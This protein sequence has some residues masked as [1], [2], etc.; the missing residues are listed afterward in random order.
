[1]QVRFDAPLWLH[2]A[3]G[4]WHFVTVPFAVADEIEAVVGRSTRGFGSVRVRVTIGS[5]TWDT[6]VF[7]DS[8]AQS[9]V[10]PI[11]KAVRTA[12]GLEVGT[13]TFV[14]MTVLDVSGDG[15]TE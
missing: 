9:Y 3:S 7:P 4:T 11:K 15:M 13:V 2:S 5:S 10:L 8:K 12:Q 14:E 1:M 6:S